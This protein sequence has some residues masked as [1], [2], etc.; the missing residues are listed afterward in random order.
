MNFFRQLWFSVVLG[1]IPMSLLAADLEQ[2]KAEPGKALVVFTRVSGYGGAISSSIFDITGDSRQIL[3]IIK[4]KRY[5]TYQADPGERM[6]MVIGESADF[7]RARLEPGKVYFANVQARMG[8]WK[9]RFSLVPWS[10]E[11]REEKKF[12]KGIRKAKPPKERD[13]E[14]WATKNT[15]SVEKKRNKYLPAW[16]KKTENDKEER[17]LKDG[18]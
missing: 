10:H 15:N 6:F 16:H 11:E 18:V 12:Q 5:I 8:A 9:A 14:A 3:G 2:F 4:S 17:T 1:C 7:M 13:I